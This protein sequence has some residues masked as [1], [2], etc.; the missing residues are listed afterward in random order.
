LEA[1]KSV[2]CTHGSI[3]QSCKTK[4]FKEKLGFAGFIQRLR[5]LATLAGDPHNDSQMPITLVP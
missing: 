1:N 3:P 2:S 5:T 4:L